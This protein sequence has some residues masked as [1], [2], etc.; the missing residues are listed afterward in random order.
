MR[1]AAL[2]GA[3]DLPRAAAA[4]AA[5]TIL[6]FS[7]SCGSSS[8]ILTTPSQ[9][10]CGLQLKAEQEAF[11]P[12]GGAGN[13]RIT[14]NRECSWSVRTESAW[15]RLASP[16]SGQGDGTVPFTVAPNADP[17]SRAAAATVEDQRLQISQEG[18]RCDF[19]VS[20]AVETVDPP[21][22]ERTIDV[23]T[24]SAQCRWTAAADV[25]WITIVAG[26]EGSGNGAVTFRVDGVSG[27]PRTGTLTIAGHRVP[28]EQGTGC[29][30]SVGTT[31]FSLGSAGGTR[32]VPVDAPPGCAWTSQSETSWISIINGA[33]GNGAG[34]VGVR[35]APTEGPAR[36]GTL[37]VGG[38]RIT[39]TQSPGCTYPVDPA[40][41]G[42]PAA[43]GP[44]AVTVNAPPGCGWGASSSVEWITVTAGQS[45]NGAGQ[46]RFNVA[47]NSGPERSGA[48]RIAESIFTI[49]Q[50][51]GCGLSLSRSRFDAGAA[52]G[53][54]AV[55]VAG[56]P[57]CA[58]SAAATAP[59]ITIT[60]G[61]AGTGSGQVQFSLAANQG[62]A[63]DASLSIGGQTLAIAQASGC[64]YGVAPGSQ[65]VG[66]PGGSSAASVTTGPGC[67]WTA[68]SAVNWIS[69]MSASGAGP[70][71]VSYAVGANQ[72]PSR[73]GTLTVAGQVLTIRQA[74]PCTWVLAPPSHVFGAGGGAGNVLVIVSGACTW[75]ASSDVGWITMTAGTNG[76]G[77]GLVQFVAAPN[78]GPARTGWLTIAGERYE[79]FQG[80]R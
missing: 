5:A 78:A 79:V 72:G 69:I 74:S 56:G 54:G 30:S 31:A 11:T 77:N 48:L 4:L 70:G 3:F 46:V 47:A 17:V 28:V 51:S 58:W 10:R 36:I 25:P 65:D 66:G 59:W 68:S 26:R 62:P 76:T 24:G 18:R 39:V 50:S 9:P 63:R 19:R 2:A 43:G 53:A 7:L 1:K 73:T 34:T 33:S 13:I 44:A 75:T 60:A 52:A 27:P 22:A 16:S 32:D 20:S 40:R 29:R 55:D 67:P 23:T 21:G 38:H 57:G 71:Q 45:G 6:L 49:T 12:D 35:V 14:T 37:T 42:A 41:Y 80:G 61:A 64:T 8:E 15:L